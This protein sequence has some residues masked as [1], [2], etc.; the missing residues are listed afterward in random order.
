MYLI[1]F[2]PYHLQLHGHLTLNWLISKD[3]IYSID[4]C[5]FKLIQLLS[6][7]ADLTCGFTILPLLIFMG[8]SRLKIC[9]VLNNRLFVI[10]MIPFEEV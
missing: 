1:I 6:G 10:T 8:N 2:T 3:Y 7:F 4:F 5:K 9:L